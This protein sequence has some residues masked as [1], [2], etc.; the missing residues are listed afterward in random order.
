MRTPELKKVILRLVGNREFYGYEIHKQLEERKISIGIGRL[1]SILTDMK[2]EGYLNDRWEKSQSGPKRRVY[3][4]AEKGES[5]REEILVDAIKTV[6]EFYT[7]YLF[8][9]PKES[10]AF[11]KISRVLLENLP[12]SANMAYV[13]TRFTKPMRKIMESLQEIS[14][15]GKLYAVHPKSKGADLELGN[16]SVIDG[17]FEDIPMKDDYLDLLMVS[18]NITRNCLNS[19]LKEWQRVV[20]PKGT[21]ALVIPTALLADYTDPL[22]IGEFIEQREHPRSDSEEFLSEGQLVTEMKKFFESVEVIK[23]IHISILRGRNVL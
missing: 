11:N 10:S 23:V 21:A 3:K 9:L 5:A 14:P 12:S 22:D 8:N 6:H 18:G 4:I 15:E 2:K 1:Y 13:T 16:I 7:D 20:N 17:T 19:C